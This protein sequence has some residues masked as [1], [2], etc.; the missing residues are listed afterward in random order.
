[1]A[2][3]LEVLKLKVFPVNCGH[4]MSWDPVTTGTSLCGEITLLGL[5]SAIRLLIVTKYDCLFT[6]LL[7]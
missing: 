1:M 3:R 7:Q 2:S 6:T 5:A 4:V